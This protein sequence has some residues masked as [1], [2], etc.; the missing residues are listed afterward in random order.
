GWCAPAFARS[1]WKVASAARHTS[2]R[3]RACCVRRSMP[4]WPI[5][6]AFRRARSG[7]RPWTKSPKAVATRSA[8]I[9]VPGNDMKLSL[10][11]I[12]Y[13][14]ERDAVFAFYRQVAEWPVDIV[15]LGEVVCSKRRELRRDDWLA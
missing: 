2:R 10:G 13:F 15:Y 8:P 11:P 3:L 6:S 7:S 1:R 5:R 9:I 14:W 12:H 4:A